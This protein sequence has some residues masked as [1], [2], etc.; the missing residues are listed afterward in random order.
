MPQHQA[1]ET[2]TDAKHWL[3]ASLKLYNTPDT[4]M[5]THGQRFELMRQ[6]YAQI[7]ERVDLS[8]LWVFSVTSFIRDDIMRNI[9]NNMWGGDLQTELEATT[10]LYCPGWQAAS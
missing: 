2:E 6:A 3:A 4:R 5:Q 8:V 7:R 1:T 10:G 9:N